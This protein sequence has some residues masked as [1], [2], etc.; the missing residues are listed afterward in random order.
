MMS[1][2]S[3]CNFLQTE[4]LGIT[5]L[6]EEYA[7]FHRM[8]VHQEMM[9]QISRYPALWSYFDMKSGDSEVNRGEKASNANLNNK[10]HQ[11]QPWSRSVLVTIIDHLI[12]MDIKISFLID[13]V[14]NYRYNLEIEELVEIVRSFDILGAEKRLFEYEALL[15]IKL[16]EIEENKREWQKRC[17]ERLPMSFFDH[18]EKFLFIRSSSEIIGSIGSQ[19]LIEYFLETN[20]HANKDLIFIQLCANGNLFLAQWLYQLGNV[21]IH[22]EYDDAFHEACIHG[23]FPIIKWLYSLG[24]IDIHIDED[25]AFRVA[26]ENG[27]LSIA[28]WLYSLGGVDIHVENDEAFRLACRNGHLSVAQWL[29]NYLGRVDIHADND[30]AIRGACYFGHLSVAQWLYELGGVDFHARD[31][32]GFR[33]ACRNGHLS[34]AQ[35]LYNLGGVNI[36]ANDDYSFQYACLNDHLSVAQWLYDLGGR[37]ISP[38]VFQACFNLTTHNRVRIWLQSINVAT[39]K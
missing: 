21:N 30:G 17:G 26:C 11:L 24:G 12:T 15:Y 18:I 37:E 39:N 38:Q 27:H 35:W 28:Q 3:F 31:E 20:N 29:Y 8:S 9:D 4:C 2:P 14:E 1:F 36:H 25:D 34:L 13:I 10:I 6:L 19:R 7:E 22:T 32:E 5:P 23:H 33:M 16:N